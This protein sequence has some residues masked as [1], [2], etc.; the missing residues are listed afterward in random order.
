MIP[1]RT[2][3]RAHYTDNQHSDYKAIDPGKRLRVF[4]RHDQIH[5]IR[6][7]QTRSI[8]SRLFAEKALRFATG[9]SA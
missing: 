5:Q 6:I 2:P 4:C 1:V 7:M 9:L 3:N 8:L